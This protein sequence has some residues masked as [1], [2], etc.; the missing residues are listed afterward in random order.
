MLA[1]LATTAEDFVLALDGLR[2]LGLIQRDGA[3]YPSVHYPPITMYPARTANEILEGYAPPADGLFT[4]YAHVPFCLK[5]CAFC[6]Y[7]VKFLASGHEMERY[8]DTLLAE[9]DLWRQRLGVARIPS[10][11]ILLGGGT[12]TYLSPRLLARFMEGFASRLDRTR[13]TQFNAD[14]DP[15][16]LIGPQGAER[17]RI[18]RDHGVDRLTIGVQSLD[19]GSLKRMNRH[20]DA[21]EAIR[22]IHACREAGFKLN[23]EF[24]FG[25]PGDTLDSWQR[26]V[27]TAVQ[28]P[29]EEIQLYRL[30]M[31]P[32][33]DRTAPLAKGFRKLDQRVPEVREALQMKALAHDILHAHGFYENLTR[34][35]TRGSEHYSHYASDQCCGLLDQIG[36]GQTA[37]SSLRDRFCLNTQDFK[38]YYDRVEGGHLPID[39]GTLR[40]LDEQIRWAIILPLK[41]AA[42]SKSLFRARTGLPLERVFRR[43]VARLKGAGL[44]AEDSQS[45]ILTPLGRFYADEVC[46]QFHHPD[47]MPFDRDAFA[48]GPLHPYRNW[49]C[50]EEGEPSR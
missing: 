17:L 37:F 14:V 34:V 41:N 31:I 36:I 10:R 26:V 15:L 33:G 24:I 2:G 3:F 8:V 25:Y 46:Q 1:K 6:H 38:T 21:A 23:I 11:S 9:L 47:H 19:D 7:P 40:N 43:K 32:Y 18:L 35:F 4:L 42:V 20:H 13:N 39:R 29:V 49:Q 48:D 50:L 28:Q 27:E 16:T 22:A 30:K 5:A 44:L 45:L 12:P